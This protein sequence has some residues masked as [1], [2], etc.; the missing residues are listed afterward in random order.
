MRYASYWQAVKGEIGFK[1][2]LFA[3]G[4]IILMLIIDAPI[5]AK[6][7]VLALFYPVYI[8]FNSLVQYI[9]HRLK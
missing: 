2:S 8:L 6:L 7:V 3:V 5:Q 1:S 9:I 4:S